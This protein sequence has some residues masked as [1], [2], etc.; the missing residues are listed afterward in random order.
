MMDL[1]LKGITVLE[2]CQYLSGPS[3]AL[4]LADLGAT[5]IKI[6]RPIKGDAGRKLAIKNLWVDESS[7]LFHTVNRNKENMIADLKNAEDLQKIKL[8]IE[9]ADV[10]IHNFR[11]GVMEKNGLGYEELKLIN[12]KLVYAAISGYGNA[13]KW[14]N[15]PGQDL[16]IQAITGLTYTT[17]NGNNGPVPFG[18]AI[19]D[20]L[21]GAQLVQGIIAGLIRKQKTGIG[22]L[23]E[24]SLMETLLDFQFELL[25]TYFK[26]G[27]L[28]QRS[29]INN[30]HSLL[31][32]PYGIYQ[33]ANGHI[34]LAMMDLH[35]MAVAIELYELKKYKITDAFTKRDEIKE[36]LGAYL[37]KEKSEYWL[38]K[39]HESNLWA[40]EVFDWKK[41]KQHDAYKALEIEQIVNANGKDFRTTR[42]PIKIN[43]ERLVSAKP[44]P[45]L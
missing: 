16:L 37:L 36:I 9:K 32:A 8:L 23:I 5:V 17:G 28:P 2:F 7:M 19:G 1:P 29:K 15:K 24:I 41:M 33:T 31:G 20:M 3:A 42:C 26:T 38:T 21:C 18:L 34:A 14:K 11:P 4:R 44:S 43:G 45:I 6:E 22:A 25:T 40:M 12:P 13:G 35:E 27:K 39:L 10:L 30:G